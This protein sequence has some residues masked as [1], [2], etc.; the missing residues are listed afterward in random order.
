[1]EIIR[2]NEKEIVVKSNKL[3][4]L[5]N[6]DYDGLCLI[7]ERKVKSFDVNYHFRELTKMVNL[8]R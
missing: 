6:A 4:N 1:M 5:M 7:S 2:V 3:L 8:K